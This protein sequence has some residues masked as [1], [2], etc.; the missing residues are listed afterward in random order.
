MKFRNHL[1][2]NQGGVEGGQDP[3][4]RESQKI[5]LLGF[6]IWHYGTK[7]SKNFQQFSNHFSIFI[8]HAK[9]DPHLGLLKRTKMFSFFKIFQAPQEY[10]NLE[11]SKSRQNGLKIS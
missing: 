9:V 2:K 11:Q 7:F 5:D 10:L 4:L 8:I 6:E 3:I 1:N